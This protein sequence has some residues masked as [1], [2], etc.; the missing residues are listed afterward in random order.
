M[1]FVNFVGAAHEIAGRGEA[2]FVDF[3][4]GTR[5][6]HGELDGCGR[7][8]LAGLAEPR[9]KLGRG[10]A[11]EDGEFEGEV[12]VAEEASE[13][14]T[15]SLGGFGGGAV[16]MSAVGVAVAT[17]ATGGR[18]IVAGLDDEVGGGATEGE[19]GDEGEWVFPIHGK[20]GRGKLG[21][22]GGG[23]QVFEFDEG[24]VVVGGGGDLAAAGGEEGGLG[25]ELIAGV[26]AACGEAG[27]EGGEPRSGDGD[28]FIAGGSV[29]GAC[30]PE[31]LIQREERGADGVEGGLAFRD[32]AVALGPG[33]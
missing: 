33:F 29:R 9:A 30:V 4:T 31:F 6:L 19:N 14:R 16:A 23:E 12:A 26:V 21:R 3:A 5:E 15:F 18:V 13:V 17:V 8:R 27:V 11:L 2:V 10:A 32:G 22:R 28:E 7:E 1:R 20:S 25:F 24:G